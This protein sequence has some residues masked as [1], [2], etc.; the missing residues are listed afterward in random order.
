MGR[1]IPVI[2]ASLSEQGLVSWR[3]QHGKSFDP[4]RYHPSL[5]EIYV[6]CILQ[7]D[8]LLLLIELEALRTL[9]GRQEA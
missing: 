1:L 3:W 8:G 5:S 4:E 9:D 7:P 2:V 6:V